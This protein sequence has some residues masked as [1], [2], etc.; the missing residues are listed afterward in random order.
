MERGSVDEGRLNP[1][2]HAANYKV[3]HDP[4]FLSLHAGPKR[5]GDMVDA[6]RDRGVRVHAFDL[7]RSLQ[8]DLLDQVTWDKIIKN[9]RGGNYEGGYAAP[10]CFTFALSRGLG[11]S[12]GGPG[13]RPI[14]GEHPPEIY[15]LP[16][17]TMEE[18]TKVREGTACALRAVEMAWE[19]EAQGLPWAIESRDMRSGHPHV[20]KLPEMEELRSKTGAAISIF[21][22]A[23]FGL[24]PPSPL[25]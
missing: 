20:F 23:I 10:P 22:S 14:R 16:G 19:M 25:S 9:I 13:P 3:D 17:L 15:G 2:W 21:S 11:S 12:A 18:K 8:H 7:R 5:R 4:G 6:G 1:P 24:G